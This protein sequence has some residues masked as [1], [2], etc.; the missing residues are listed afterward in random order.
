MELDGSTLARLSIALMP[1][2][3]VELCFVTL[4][5]EGR[6][7]ELGLRIDEE[8]SPHEHEDNN[9]CTLDGNNHDEYC[10][11]QAARAIAGRLVVLVL[12][13]HLLRLLGRPNLLH[14]ILYSV[15]ANILRVIGCR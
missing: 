11:R 14:L 5:P 7:R 4:A 10:C 2:S 13:R 15:S 6:L 8:D 1:C 9:D 12:R 3:L